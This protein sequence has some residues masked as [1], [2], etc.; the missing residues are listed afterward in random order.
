M[1]YIQKKG[2]LKL[3]T[4]KQYEQDENIRSKKFIKVMVTIPEIFI[5]PKDYSSQQIEEETL[6]Y[7]RKKYPKVQ[8][9]EYKEISRLEDL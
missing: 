2:V 6:E 8:T 3:M 7:L 5:Y 9:F 1:K 4:N